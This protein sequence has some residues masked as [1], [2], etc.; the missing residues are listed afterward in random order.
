MVTS[1]CRTI[2]VAQG[3]NEGRL[4]EDVWSAVERGSSQ[5]EG[6]MVRM[7][8]GNPRSTEL[9]M[10]EGVVPYVGDEQANVSLTAAARL[11]N[12]CALT[13]SQV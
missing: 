12:P 4:E 2:C 8:Y 3:Q 11:N 6:R 10:I 1:E 5:E 9:S 13:L 7:W